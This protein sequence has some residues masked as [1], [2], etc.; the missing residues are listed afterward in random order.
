MPYQVTLFTVILV[1]LVGI[2]AATGT[3]SYPVGMKGK[4]SMIAMCAIVAFLGTLAVDDGVRSRN[5]EE[6]DP[7]EYEVLASWH[8][9]DA[10][11]DAMVADAMK[12]RRIVRA[13]MDPIATRLR[14]V[15][16]DWSRAHLE[17]VA[18][19]TKTK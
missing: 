4:V 6:I 19:E 16:T 10:R 2:C 12:D 1:I 18:K 15:K 8:G 13:E 3:L 17:D 11:L 9:V 7:I 5:T 14:T